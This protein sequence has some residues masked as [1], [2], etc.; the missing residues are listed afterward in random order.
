MIHRCPTL[1]TVIACFD[2]MT[3]VEYVIAFGTRWNGDVAYIDDNGDI[4]VGFDPSEE[5]DGSSETPD[6]VS[7]MMIEED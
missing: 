7:P 4:A 1:A 6:Y 2:P 3:E 5:Y